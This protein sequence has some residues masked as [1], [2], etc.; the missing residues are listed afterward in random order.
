MYTVSK[1][2]IVYSFKSNTQNIFTGH[3]EEI[4]SFAMHPGRLMVCTGECGQC[5]RILMWHSVTHEIVYASDK[6][7]ETNGVIQ[8]AFNRDGKQLLR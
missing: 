7:I 3:S 8:L 6:N 1:Y 4:I 5:G 2:G